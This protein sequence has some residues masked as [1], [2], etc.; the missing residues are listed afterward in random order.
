MSIN[1]K[2]EQEQIIS[3]A[4]VLLKVAIACLI[5]VCHNSF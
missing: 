5:S 3:R 2:L 4:I 1:V